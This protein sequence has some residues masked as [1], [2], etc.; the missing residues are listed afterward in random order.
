MYESTVRTSASEDHVTGTDREMELPFTSRQIRAVIPFFPQST[1]S[2]VK[3]Y[4]AVVSGTS[5]ASKIYISLTNFTPAALFL[6]NRIL[7]RL[8]T[9]ELCRELR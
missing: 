6:Y 4:I 7:F 9:N 2:A 5:F 1:H 8:Y 3:F